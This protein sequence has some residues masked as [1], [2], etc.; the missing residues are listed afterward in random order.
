M[1]PQHEQKTH[2]TGFQMKIDKS[3]ND[4]PLK[5]KWMEE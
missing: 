2:N 1:T 4:E 3:T 5:N